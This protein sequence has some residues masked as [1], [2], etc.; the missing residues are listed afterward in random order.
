MNKCPHC[1][2][3]IQEGAQFCLYCMEPL[4][5]KKD[6]TPKKKKIPLLP[7]IIAL[8]V[9]L[10]SVG[11]A[12][13]IAL[14]KD[15][16]KKSTDKDT[17]PAVTEESRAESESESESESEAESESD[18]SETDAPETE[19]REPSAID[20]IKLR[21]TYLTGKS[22]LSHL[23]DPDSF[24]LTHSYTDDD[25]DTWEIYSPDVYL[26][27]VYISI[28]LCEGGEEI[29]TTV[30]SVS[31]EM[32]DDALLLCECLISSVYNYTYTN[33]SDLLSSDRKY[34]MSVVKDG[35]SLAALAGQKDTEASLFDKK[36]EPI[37][38]R[39]SID[40][41]DDGGVDMFYDLR[42][43]T[44]KGDTFYDIYFLHFCE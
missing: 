43:R 33:L 38:K 39:M 12:L 6:I 21:A 2:S 34:P 13:F 3:D 5:E 8:S 25:G 17:A 20:D 32:R 14:G 26:D 35:V 37:L 18:K 15:S 31:D 27:G 24:I 40:I 36:S 44:Y 42:Q 16:N 28:S 29:L 10:I 22:G 30:A 11:A 19:D 7:I 41:N 9:I 23:W 1:G 4:N